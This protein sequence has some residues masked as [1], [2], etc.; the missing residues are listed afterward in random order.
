MRLLRWV[1]LANVV[2]VQGLHDANPGEHRR[3]AERGTCF[4]GFALAFFGL[5]LDSSS[6]R[7]VGRSACFRKGPFDPTGRLRMTPGMVAATT[8][9]SSLSFATP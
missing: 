6:E 8:S 3:A 7:C 5:W 9:G 1:E 4:L 2:T